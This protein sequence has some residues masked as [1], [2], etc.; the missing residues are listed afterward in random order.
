[1]P[2]T[3]SPAEIFGVFR[4]VLKNDIRKIAVATVTA[5]NATA[6][7]VDVQLCTNNPLFDDAGNV[8]MEPAASIAGVP[9]GCLRGGGFMIW[10]PV[11]VGD[12]VLILFTDL[13]ADTWRSGDGSPQDPAWLGVHTADSAFALPMFAPDSRPLTSPPTDATKIIIGQDGSAAQIR[14]GADI[15]LGSPATDFVALASKVLTELTKIQATLA[16]GANSGGPVVFSL[17]YVPSS[18]A[19]A[20]VRSQ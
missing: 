6:Q 19:S 12:S 8:F 4:D 14:I 7:T 16:T 5:V 3:R 11:A 2:L 13:S 10:L 15:E 9:L 17:P 18:V 20:L 1:M